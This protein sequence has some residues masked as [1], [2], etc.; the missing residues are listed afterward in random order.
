MR[1][2]NPKYRLEFEKE[3]MDYWQRIKDK[4]AEMGKYFVK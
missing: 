1:D 2:P 4:L 3:T